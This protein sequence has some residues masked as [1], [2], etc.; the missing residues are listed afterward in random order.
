VIE[1]LFHKNATRTFTACDAVWHTPQMPGKR[2]SSQHWPV[3]R[4]GRRQQA[5]LE[6]PAFA[7][8]ISLPSRVR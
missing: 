6:L 5:A 2:R 4:T 8:R 3:L 7:P 1:E